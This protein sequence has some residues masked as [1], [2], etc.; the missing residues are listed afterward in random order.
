MAKTTPITGTVYEDSGAYLMARV[1]GNAGTMITQASLSALTYK[2]FDLNSD[3]PFTPT[4]SG[5]LTVSAVVFDTLQTDAR[6]SADST[7][8]N[9]GH[10]IP[11]AWLTDGGHVFKIEYRFTPVSG[12]V[13]HVVFQLT[14]V[15]LLG[16]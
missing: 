7:G 10:V 6:W 9:F 13:F 15:D 8:Y 2:V 5:S 3:A 16:S 11:A 4:Q 1:I 14:T 12:E